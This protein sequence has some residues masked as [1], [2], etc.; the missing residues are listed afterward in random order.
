MR[1]ADEARAAGDLETL[2]RALTHIDYADLQMGRA[3]LGSNTREAVTLFEGLGDLGFESVARSNLGGYAFYAGRWEEAVDWYTSSRRLEVKIGRLYS[4]A[5][6]DVALG[7]ILIHQRHFDRAD[8]VL[9]EAVRVLRASGVESSCAYGEMQQARILLARG[10][11]DGA[12]ELAGR[13]T[14]TFLALDSPVTALEATL[15]RAEAEV[16][17]GRPADALA[18]VAAAEQATRG[19]GASLIARSSLVRSRALLALGRLEEAGQMIE[20]GLDSAIEQKLPYEQALLL[21]ARSDWESCAVGRW[22][23]RQRPS[24]L[25]TPPASST[26]SGF[27]P[28]SSDLNP[29]RGCRSGLPH[30]DVAVDVDLLADGDLRW[31]FVANIEV[32]FTMQANWP[33]SSIASVVVFSGG[34]PTAWSCSFATVAMFFFTAGRGVGVADPFT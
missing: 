2:A 34:Y 23:W 31:V 7:E 6:I 25:R 13:V 18:T 30:Q 19:E 32:W 28:E 21:L 16:A 9:G 22:R 3:D 15:V 17:A 24:M 26:R 11:H 27:R 8:E 4:A 14:A 20:T 1:A 5:E 10:D 29:E 33:V 12:R